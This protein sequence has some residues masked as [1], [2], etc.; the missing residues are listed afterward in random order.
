MHFW[1]FQVVHSTAVTCTLRLVYTS[2]PLYFRQKTKSDIQIFECKGFRSSFKFILVD[3]PIQFTFQLRQVVVPR[4][5]SLFRGNEWNEV[6]RNER[7]IKI[8]TCQV[9]IT[10]HSIY[11]KGM[12]MCFIAVGLW[13][14]GTNK[15]Y[16]GASWV[17]YDKLIFSNFNISIF[18]YNFYHISGFIT[19]MPTG[20]ISNSSQYQT[21]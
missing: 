4:E 14:K 17:S 8:G 13:T 18:F 6:E 7:L 2:K 15:F 20:K 21:K 19:L 9:L 12:C 16:I 1:C 5:Q 10:I 11:A 3:N